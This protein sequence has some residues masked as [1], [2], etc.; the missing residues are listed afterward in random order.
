V[1]PV[2]KPTDLVVH[3]DRIVLLA[4]LAISILTGVHRAFSRQW[5]SRKTKSA[6]GGRGKAR[7]ISALVV[8]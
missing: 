1:P 3:T 4:A 5:C 7:I 6:A 2:D 8:A